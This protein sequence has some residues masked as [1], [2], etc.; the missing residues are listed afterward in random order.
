MK[1]KKI[2]RRRG[3]EKNQ[4]MTHTE[5]NLKEAMKGTQ[6]RRS[7]ARTEERRRDE[8]ENAAMQVGRPGRERATREGKKGT[9]TRRDE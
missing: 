4:N 3:K 7:L 2:N 5:R 6:K 1:M 8:R 9:L